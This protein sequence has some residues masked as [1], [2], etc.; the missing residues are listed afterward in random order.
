MFFSQALKE[1]RPRP[2]PL[3][4]VLSSPAPALPGLKII[5]ALPAKF[6]TEHRTHLLQAIMHR[7][8][9]MRACPFTFIVREFQTVII[10][11]TFPCPLGRTFG[12]GI[13]ISK[14]RGTISIHILRRFSF[15]NPLRHQFAH[16]TRAAI[17][18][19]RHT[20]RDPQA[21]CARNRSKQR[22]TIR[23]IRA[24]VTNDRDNSSLIE[25]R[26]AADSTL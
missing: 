4:L 1:R 15:D 20:C 17:A 2:T 8:D 6:L 25:E 16:T 7:A 12:V 26:N 3:T 5:N 22:L 9:S 21:A 10:F 14:A 18:V 11:D 19:E 13:I 24:G 23:R